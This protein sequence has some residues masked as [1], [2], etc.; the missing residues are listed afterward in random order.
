MFLSLVLIIILSIVIFV[1]GSYFAKASSL[2]GQALRL[3]KGVK[4]ATFDAVS[5]SL[6]ELMIALF[7][8]ISFGQFEVGVGT[9]AGSALFN[10]LVIPAV[11]VLVAGQTL[12]VSKEVAVRDN[13]FHLLSKILLLLMVYVFVVWNFYLALVLIFCYVI[14]VVVLA[15][16]KKQARTETVTWSKTKAW[17]IGL[18]SLGVVATAAYFLT[19]QSILFAKALHVPP[20]LIAFTVIAVATSIPDLV[21]SVVNARKKS[22]DDAV[23]NVLGSNTFDIL[24]AL[25]LPL[26]LATIQTP[27][28]PQ[29]LYPELVV[30]LFGVTCIFT[31]L[32]FLQRRLSR[33]H[34]I[35]FLLAYVLI[36]LYALV[37]A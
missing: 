37:L 3:S 9:I 16:A 25:G 11:S 30:L 24:I 23:A 12:R 31:L 21:I 36:T 15:R 17:T 27:L 32:L 4:G 6:P 14:Y 28:Q 1:A 20:L 13:L 29:I 5:S 7:S 2:A 22:A 26:A 10:L 34:A 19:E 18:F 33:T 35:F 8:V